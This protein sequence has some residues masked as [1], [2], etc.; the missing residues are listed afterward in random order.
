MPSDVKNELEQM[1]LDLD[2]DATDGT[3]DSSSDGG[4][5]DGGTDNGDPSPSDGSPDAVVTPEV[6]AKS[7]DPWKAQVDLLMAGQQKLEGMFSQVLEK[8]GSPA[9]AEEQQAQVAEQEKGFELVNQEEFDKVLSGDVATLNGLLNRAVQKGFEQAMLA[10]PEAV[11]RRVETSID[12]KTQVKMFFNAN[13][14]LVPHRRILGAIAQELVEQK[15]ELARDAGKLLTE[16]GADLRKRFNLVA[17][18]PQKRPAAS[19]PSD[20]GGRAP[21]PAAPTQKPDANDIAAQIA[22]QF[23]D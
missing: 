4:A 16:A 2:G 5:P 20:L 11:Q 1:F 15:P 23:V 18:S 17:P 3:G 14:D 21:K 7:D 8:I 12:S 10:V 22:E 6:E 19:P 13:A 9:K